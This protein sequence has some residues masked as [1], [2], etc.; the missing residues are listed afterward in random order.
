MRYAKGYP[1]LRLRGAL[2]ST[3]MVFICL[4]APRAG[5]QEQ[6]SRHEVSAQFTTIRFFDAAAKRYFFGVGGRYDFNFNRR[7]AFETQVDFFPKDIFPVYQRQGGKLTHVLVGVRAK[8]VQSRHFSVY[9]VLRPSLLIFTNVP[10]YSGPPGKLPGFTTRPQAQLALN[11]G[12]GVEY[13]P[14]PRLIARFEISGDP[15]R[16]ANTL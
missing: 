4:L 1:N 10:Q 6:F 16:F 14:T 9:G 2:W 8:A 7:I 5:A 13:Y 15:T 12:G 3:S 11:L